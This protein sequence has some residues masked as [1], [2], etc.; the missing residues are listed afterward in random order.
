MA[1]KL[2]EKYECL[3]DSTPAAGRPVVRA[4]FASQRLD[5]KPH[6]DAYAYAIQCSRDV[7]KAIDVFD[8]RRWLISTDFD[9]RSSVKKREYHYRVYDS[10]RCKHKMWAK[11]TG[12]G[13]QRMIS[14]YG[15][16]DEPQ[17]TKPPEIDPTFS[18]AG[19]LRQHANEQVTRFIE[20]T[21]Y[22]GSKDG[23]HGAKFSLGGTNGVQH[24]TQK[25]SNNT[26][27][28]VWELENM[29][30]VGIGNHTRSNTEYVYTDERGQKRNFRFP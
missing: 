22:R 6:G 13:N 30:V 10:G 5:E 4:G 15:L 21:A 12:L 17:D 28:Y 26:I 18:F 7:W 23:I 14:F 16:D 1:E 11:V 19:S 3:F 8:P 9:T 2:T 29:K 27:F 24:R 20:A 25:A